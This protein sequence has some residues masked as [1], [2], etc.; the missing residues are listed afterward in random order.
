MPL[1]TPSAGRV[2]PPSP[3]TLI[4]PEFDRFFRTHERVV[5]SFSAIPFNEI[6]TTLITEGYI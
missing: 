4:T 2:V 3:G 5:W 6:D 1:V